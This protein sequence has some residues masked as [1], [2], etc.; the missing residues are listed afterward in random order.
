ME[1]RTTTPLLD[2]KGKLKTQGWARH[3][4]WEYDRKRSGLKIALKEWDSY[5]IADEENGF[6][7]QVIYSDLGYAGIFSI[8]FFDYNRRKAAEVHGIKLFPKTRTL[9][10]DPDS[11]SAVTYANSDMT[12]AF[13]KKGRKHQILITA[14]YL[15]LP[16]GSSGFKA[17]VILY[18][19]DGTESMNTAS[20]FDKDGRYWHY[21]RRINPMKAE[22]VIFINH[23]SRHL[24]E[25]KSHGCM[26]W[27]RG[28]WPQKSGWTAV[29]LTGRTDDG[30]LWGVDL[31]SFLPECMDSE[32]SAVFF[33]GRIHKLRH[34]AFSSPESHPSIGYE[35][36][37]DE[38][39]IRLVF[40]PV[41]AFE[42]TISMKM[43]KADRKQQAGLFSGFFLLDDG[44][45]IEVDKAYGSVTEI[46][47]RW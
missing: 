42:D 34:I 41:A 7:F 28:R 30:T 23:I 9:S 45:R 32:G 46:R 31:T 25:D 27:E 17:D 6:T 33:Y 38:N 1:L 2:E 13:V 16:D 24:S 43:M 29:S 10:E 8:A 20:A 22:G 11:D 21:G 35:I 5:S 19:S 14:P 12:I 39:R 18:E 40:S 4:Y 15:T 26:E 37:D 36:T 3:P 44:Q 47:S